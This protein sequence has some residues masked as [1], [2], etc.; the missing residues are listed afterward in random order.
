VWAYRKGFDARR[1]LLVG[2]ALW[3]P[4]DFFEP[5]ALRWRGRAAEALVSDRDE[6][7]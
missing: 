2:D 6:R 5:D 7:R 4:L 3:G 1:N